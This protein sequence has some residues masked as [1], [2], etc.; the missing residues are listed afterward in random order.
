MRQ[1]LFLLTPKEKRRGVIVL[2]MVT[3]MAALETAGVASVIPFLSVLG[4]PDVVHTNPM[5][6]SFFDAGNFQSVD[7]FLLALGGIAFA[8]I[9]FSALF[10]TL[11]HYTMNRFIEMRRHSIAERLLET[12]LRQPYAFFLDRHSSD[13]AK[14]IL[15]EVDQLVLYVFRPGVQMV[16]YGVVA[17][18]IV[19]L[20]VVVDPIVATGV[21]MVVGGAYALIFLFL[22]GLLSRIGSDRARANQERFTAAAEALGGIKDIK[23]LGREHAY[24]MRFRVPS[25]RQARHIATTQTLSQIPKFII[26]AVG[27]GGIIALTL[28]LLATQGGTTGGALGTVLPMLGLYAF[29]GF[30][31]L[32]AAQHIYNG[33]ARLRFGRAAVDGVYRDLRQRSALAEIR[34]EPPRS[35]TP[36]RSITLQGVSYTYPNA[37]AAALKEIDVTIPVGTSVGL[38]G[39]T[40]AGKTTLVDVILGLLRPTEGAITV[41]GQPVTNAN[42]RAWQKSLGYVPQEIFLTDSTVAEN[43]ALGVSP[44]LIN[45]RQVV[46]CAQMAQVHNFIIEELPNQYESLVGERGVRLSG[47]QRQRIGIARALYHDPS[48]LVLDEATSALDIVTEQA[49]MESI[50][51]LSRK[52]TVILIAHR[53]STVKGCDQIVLLDN[54]QAKVLHNEMSQTGAGNFANSGDR[55]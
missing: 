11:T 7:D 26:E 17:I 27:L 49:V 8:L 15:S 48:V 39:K 30:R 14:T 43:I 53:Q 12:Y 9:L 33:V 45:Y 34:Q 42:L 38:V 41:D 36:K 37:P 20:L 29:A 55:S 47:G 18:A 4:N 51:L 40:G 2:V 10:R 1:I 13:M 19:I 25:I 21:A 16:A 52:K 46:Q 23:L 32:P 24:L 50:E 44:E 35:L 54:G 3:I 31:L 5:L 28:V 6:A 22:R